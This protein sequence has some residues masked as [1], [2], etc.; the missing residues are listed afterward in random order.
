MTSSS[1]TPLTRGSSPEGG[2]APLSVVREPEPPNPAVERSI[3]RTVTLVM[4]LIALLTFAFSF[5]NVWHL[6]SSLGVPAW[7]APLVGPAVDLSVVGL[8]LG[9]QYLTLRTPHAVGLRP[10]R[11]LLVF[12]GLATLALNVAEPVTQGQFGR[13]AVDAVAPLLLIGWSEVGPG[14]LRQIYCAGSDFGGLSIEPQQES[15]RSEDQRGRRP[16]RTPRQSSGRTSRGPTESDS[17]LLDRAC[18]ADERH[19]S[20][21]GRPISAEN[22]RRELEISSARARAIAAKMRQG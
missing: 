18:R 13:A 9:I 3:A 2:S 20:H 19:Q 5:G 11:A 10:A 4:A 15:D 21:H 8:L 16:R 1:I 14:L 22:L 17:V 7:I 6:A 12:S